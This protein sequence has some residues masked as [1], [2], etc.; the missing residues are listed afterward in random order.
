MGTDASFVMVV[1]LI[2]VGKALHFRNLAVK[3]FLQSVG[4]SMPGIGYDVVDIRFEAFG[5]LDHRWK[6]RVIGP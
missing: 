5:G 2:V 3:F 4:N 1:I 6:A